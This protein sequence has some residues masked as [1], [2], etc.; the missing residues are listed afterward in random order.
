MAEM[1]FQEMEKDGKAYSAMIAGASKFR[2]AVRAETLYGEMRNK[3]LKGTVEAYNGLLT[4]VPL[5][6]EVGDTRWEY[7]MHILSHMSSD[8]VQ[9]NLHT[10]NALLEIISKS[11]RWNKSRAT[12]LN[13]LA[14]MKNLNI[15]PSLGTYQYILMIFYGD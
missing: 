11:A 4:V 3:E 10:M 5:L 13:V 15:D 14:E 12:A 9:P 2:D 1:L 8:G 6:Q 7:A